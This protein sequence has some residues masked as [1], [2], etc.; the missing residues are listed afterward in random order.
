MAKKLGK[1]SK[2]FERGYK[3]RSSP[4]ER[5][6][7]DL[8]DISRGAIKRVLVLDD[9][10]DITY[11]L[12][13]ILESHGYEVTTVNTAVN[14]LVPVMVADFDA[15]ICDMVMPNMPGDMFYYAVAQA[16]PHLCSRF[17]FITAHRSN[18][19][20]AKFLSQVERPVLQKPFGM[21]D[22]L[23][24]ILETIE[25]TQRTAQ[26]RATEADLCGMQ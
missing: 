10:E 13:A 3:R 8:I 4:L 12:T 21:D 5:V 18:P 23:E 16:K 15:I 14:G 17:V 20:I 7:G 24:T 22:L 6:S 2:E 19:N 9:D 25:N 1:G 11:V 26:G